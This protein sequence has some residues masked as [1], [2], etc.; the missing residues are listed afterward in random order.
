MKLFKFY[1]KQREIIQPKVPNMRRRRRKKKTFYSNFARKKKV[2]LSGAAKKYMQRQIF[3]VFIPLDVLKFSFYPILAS[4]FFYGFFLSFSVVLPR[5]FRLFVSL[6][7]P[8]N[9]VCLFFFYRQ[10]HKICFFF[11]STFCCLLFA[12]AHHHG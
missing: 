10:T 3:S 11:S 1:H 5:L 12:L 4:S 8:D 9:F 7:S 2:M 6:L